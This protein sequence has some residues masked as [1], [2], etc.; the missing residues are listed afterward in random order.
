[1]PGRKRRAAPEGAAPPRRLELSSPPP[2]SSIPT[3]IAQSPL[4]HRQILRRPVLQLV[5][6]LPAPASLPCGALPPALASR[7]STWPKQ[8]RD[9]TSPKTPPRIPSPSTP[10]LDRPCLSSSAISLPVVHRALSTRSGMT[11]PSPAVV[12][13]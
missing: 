12:S 4:L 1:M 7:C 13:L 3:S 10:T 8:S 5:H 11:L 6:A 9:S 2:A